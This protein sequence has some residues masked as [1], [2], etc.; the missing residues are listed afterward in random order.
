MKRRGFSCSWRP[1]E[2]GFTS[3]WRSA[4]NGFTL[5]EMLVALAVLAM[6]ALALVRLDAFTVRSSAALNSNAV[7]MIVANNVA[8][9]YL[10]DPA[11]PTIG[12]NAASVANGGVNWRVATRVAATADPGLLRIDIRV[13]GVGGGHATL[14]TIRPAA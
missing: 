9:T 3:S 2:N 7:A 5:L 4:E 12:N 14:T 13:D 11:P 1:K 8:T 6:A 10:T